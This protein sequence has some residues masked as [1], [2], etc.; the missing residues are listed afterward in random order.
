MKQ[1]L[2]DRLAAL[3]IEIDDAVAQRHMDSVAHELLHPQTPA[4]SRRRRARVGTL[5]AAAML[6]VLPAAAFAAEGT[7]PGDFLY[8]IKLATEQLRQIVD[9]NIEAE[10]RI[11]ELETVVDRAGP[12]DEIDDRLADAESAVQDRDVPADLLDRL[13]VVRDRVTTEHRRETPPS[14]E[15]SADERPQDDGAE[16][17]TSPPTTSPPTTAP[18]VTTT[19]QPA[20]DRP[21][22]PDGT[23]GTTVP[24]EPDRPPR[25]DA[26]TTTSHPPGDRDHPPRDG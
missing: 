13:D 4:P 16:D 14:H 6:L 25:S 21:P 8:P 19:S 23:G 5:L 3:H 9:P 18:P 12:V 15:Q 20:T 26:G 7:V 17:R 10:H 1:D 22:H 11:E 24:P 2:K